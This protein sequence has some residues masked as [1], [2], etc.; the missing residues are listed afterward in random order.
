MVKHGLHKK[1]MKKSK[2]RLI[3]VVFYGDACLKHSIEHFKSLGIISKYKTWK[4]A[5]CKSTIWEVEE[6]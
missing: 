1:S 4:C 3:E 2:K 5:K 6:C